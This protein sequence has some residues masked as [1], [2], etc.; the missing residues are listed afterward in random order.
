[1]D[2]SVDLFRPTLPPKV[3]SATPAEGWSDIE[4]RFD[5]FLW[6]QYDWSQFDPKKFGYQ[7]IRLGV[8]GKYDFFTI[9]SLCDYKRLTRINPRTGKPFKWKPRVEFVEDEFGNTTDKVLRVDACRTE[10]RGGK[11]ITVYMHREIIGVGSG[12]DTSHGNG[13]SLDNRR[14]NLKPNRRGPNNHEWSFRD[15]PVNTTL[16]RGVVW[17]SDEKQEYVRASFWWTT[18]D[19]RRKQIRSKQHWPVAQASEAHQE[20][21][22]IKERHYR[23]R[24]FAAGGKSLPMPKFPPRRK[25]TRLAADDSLAATF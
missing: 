4:D 13:C 20:Y 6:S 5:L 22:R 1:M 23:H 7:I 24:K 11:E 2:G 14:G 12:L 3:E 16:P 8:G 25:Q 9:V 10:R 17:V 18:R 15:K 19:G 21:L